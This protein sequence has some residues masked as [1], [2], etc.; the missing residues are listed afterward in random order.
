MCFPYIHKI[1]SYSK[2]N[3]DIETFLKRIW[4]ALDFEL[5]LLNCK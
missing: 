5:K 1:P 3:Y 2:N 4:N